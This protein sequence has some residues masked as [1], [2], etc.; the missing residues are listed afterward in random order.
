MS[1]R[2]GRHAARR[3]VRR[4][5]LLA[6]GLTIAAAAAV[7]F[8]SPFIR[9]TP[10]AANPD[11]ANVELDAQRSA[12][13]DEVSRNHDRPA[14]PS[15]SPSASPPASPTPSRPVAPVAGLSQ[16]QM[17]NAAT[18]VDVAR[19]RTL[20]RQ[21]AIVAVTTALQESNLHNLAS[22]AV[23]ASL[24]LPHE[25][26][27]V[28]YDSIGLFQQRPSQGWGT[29]AQLMDPRTATGLFY[30]RLLKVSGWQGMSVADAAQAVQRSA[31]PDA[32]QK[33]EDTARRVVAAL[34]P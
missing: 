5:V 9:A 16:A 15:A 18:I 14:S 21:A 4:V 29:V 22:G 6:I 31:Y 10:S 28:N 25:G 13:V 17:N 32:Y 11:V 26:E 7:L 12:S 34:M 2:R 20:P 24:K 3:P 19:R 1:K 33:H 27:S 8:G 23:P 30:D